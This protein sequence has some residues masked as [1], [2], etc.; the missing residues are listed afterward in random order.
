MASAAGSVTSAPFPTMPVRTLLFRYAWHVTF[1]V[2]IPWLHRALQGLH[3]SS[4]TNEGQ[5]TALH[6]AI[7]EGAGPLQ[8]VALSGVAV[9]GS[10]PVGK[11][12]TLRV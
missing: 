11:Q 7:L 6:V 5:G 10:A 12:C 9:V 3:C 4:A 2:W 8:A 1:R